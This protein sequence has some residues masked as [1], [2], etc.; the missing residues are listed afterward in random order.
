MEMDWLTEP[1]RFECTCTHH[2]KPLLVQ[3]SKLE[4]QRKGVFLRERDMGGDELAELIHYLILKVH[5]GDLVDQDGTTWNFRDEASALETYLPQ[6]DLKSA[7]NRIRQYATRPRQRRLRESAVE[8]HN[9]LD[10]SRAILRC[11]TIGPCSKI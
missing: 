3:R 2:A 11:V 5:Q 9:V 6:E 4:V 7:L 10:W 1:C 8:T